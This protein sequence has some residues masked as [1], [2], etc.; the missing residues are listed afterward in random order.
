MLIIMR[1]A[2]MLA[3]RSCDFIVQIKD[4]IEVPRSLEM[5]VYMM[6]IWR[7]TKCIEF[8]DI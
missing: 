3:K 7:V 8:C 5:S 2:H 6:Y 1:E 4:N